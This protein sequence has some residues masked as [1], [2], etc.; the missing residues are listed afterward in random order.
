MNKLLPVSKESTKNKEQHRKE[1][2]IRL[3]K[4]ND[5]KKVKSPPGE[6][7][8]S[9]N[10]TVILAVVVIGL[11]LAVLLLA[12]WIRMLMT[13]REERQLVIN[14]LEQEIEVLNNNGIDETVN[15]TVSYDDLPSDP[16]PDVAENAQNPDVAQ[17]QTFNYDN[18]FEQS[19]ILVTQNQR[20]T[21][22]ICNEKAA[23]RLIEDS[24][25]DYVISEHPDSNY[26]LLLLGDWEP[27]WVVQL[28]EWE[29]RKKRLLTTISQQ[30]TSSEAAT[31]TANSFQMPEELEERKKRLLTTI[32]QQA[33]SS[34]AATQTANSFQMPEEL[35]GLEAQKQDLLIGI[36]ILSS[37]SREEVNKKVWIL[38]N[39]GIPA[40]IY[41]YPKNYSQVY[42]YTL[43]V[44]LFPTREEALVYQ[45]VLTQEHRDLFLEMI[46]NDVSRGYPR[47][48]MSND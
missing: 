11:S 8:L 5:N 10:Q 9:K 26:N 47:N 32:S 23:L 4:A 17:I 21:Y 42:Q 43:Q 31:Q 22:Y 39:E 2:G 41:S 1:P 45:E 38:R 34:E 12:F 33:T 14:R 48:I 30:A 16:S 40:Y 18:L 15:A 36:Q 20:K 37:S 46:S 35:E 27:E 3:G 28:Q 44:N 19:Q 13:Q 25:L 24:G 6:V 7:G 29:E